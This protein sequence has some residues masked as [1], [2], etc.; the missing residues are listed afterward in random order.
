[1]VRALTMLL[2]DT[3]LFLL[4]RLV[5]RLPPDREAGVVDEDVE[6]AELVDSCSNERV[7]ALRIGHVE[8]EPDIGL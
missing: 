5:E 1:M 3:L 8:L 2:E 7:A 6:A 4:T